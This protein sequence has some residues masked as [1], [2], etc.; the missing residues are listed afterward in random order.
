MVFFPDDPSSV[1]AN[2]NMSLVRTSFA[3]RQS[4]CLFTC[5]SPPSPT[6]CPRALTRVHPYNINRLAPAQHDEAVDSAGSNDGLFFGHVKHEGILL[7]DAALASTAHARYHRRHLLP[8]IGSRGH[9]RNRRSRRSSPRPCLPQWL[10][11][12]IMPK[13]TPP[14]TPAVCSTRVRNDQ[15]LWSSLSEHQRME[16]KG[17]GD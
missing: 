4:R 2:P 6:A 11:A 9:V 16:K 13:L 15:A 12:G 1:L 10:V 8:P 5:L 17:K 3:G 14:H 7:V